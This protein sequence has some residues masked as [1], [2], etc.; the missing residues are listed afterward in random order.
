MDL[1][2][3]YLLNQLTGEYARLDGTDPAMVGVYSRMCNLDHLEEVYPYLYAMRYFGWGTQAR[4]E[5]VLEELAEM[6]KLAGE[7]P[8]LSGLYADLRLAGKKADPDT[9]KKLSAAQVRGYSQV[10]LKEKSALYKAPVKAPEKAGGKT[11]AKSTGDPGKGLGKD[12]GKGLEKDTKGIKSEKKLDLKVKSEKKPEPAPRKDL[13]VEL[14]G[15]DFKSKGVTADQFDTG[16][17]DY[18]HAIVSVKPDQAARRVSVSSQIFTSTGKE[19][20][21]VFTSE[22]DIPANA[23]SFETTGWGAKTVS[24]Y[25]AGTYTWE[26]WV[27]DRKKSVRRTFTIYASSEFGKVEVKGVSTFGSKLSGALSADT[28]DCKSKF[29]A[30]TLECL[31]VKAAIREPG[32]TILAKARMRIENKDTGAVLYDRHYC[33]KVEHNFAFIWKGYGYDSPGHWKPGRYGYLLEL[34]GR[35]FE[36][37]FTVE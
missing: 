32:K 9:Q 25:P 12:L 10:Y 14:T 29:S 16:D 18:L 5:E 13:P 7:E 6:L 1:F 4:P 26:A 20:S 3:Q 37:T 30:K 36:G 28:N 21:R 23:T 17:V 35:K 8:W 24:N 11:T 33:H 2:D 22:V 27:G 15:L 31:Y 34:S 19:Q